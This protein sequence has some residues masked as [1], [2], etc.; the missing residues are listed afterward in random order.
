MIDISLQGLE[1][2][3]SQV[4]GSIGIVPLLR[5]KVRGDLR[6]FRRSYDDDLTFIPACRSHLFS[7]KL[8]FIIYICE[9]SKQRSV[10]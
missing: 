5:H 6:L 1:I 10:G 7:F 8:Y 3:P 2:A 4:W 9:Q